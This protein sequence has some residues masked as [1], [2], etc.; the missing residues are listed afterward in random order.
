MRW[1]LRKLLLPQ[2]GWNFQ[3]SD[4]F[5]LSNLQ[6]YILHVLNLNYE[7]GVPNIVSHIYEV[8]DIQEYNFEA[9]YMLHT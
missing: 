9:A 3:S 2:I 6:Q 5:Q 8:L 4:L 7:L 1:S